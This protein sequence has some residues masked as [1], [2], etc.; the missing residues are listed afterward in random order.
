VVVAAAVVDTMAGL[1]L[2]YPKVDKAKLAEIAEAR[3]A[4]LNSK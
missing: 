4:L 1:D 3:K 2:A